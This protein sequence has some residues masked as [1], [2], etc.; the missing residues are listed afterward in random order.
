M[1][2]AEFTFP[3]LVTKVRANERRIGE[4]IIVAMQT[5][6]GMLFD[7]E[8]NYNGHEAWAKPM[9]REGQA[10][11]ARGVLKKSLA[12]GTTNGNAGPGGIAQIDGQKY[13]IGTDVAYAAMMNFG[14]TKM[15]DG[16]MRPVRAKA[17]RIPLPSGK[18]ATKAAKTL[19]KGSDE[20]FIYR[21]WVRIPERRFD[22]ITQQDRE[23]FDAAFAAAVA[24]VLRG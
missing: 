12:P 2:A 3:D 23:E 13:T 5:N 6:R 24:E 15:P 20:G 7:A 19:R 8:G 10:L 9:L 14:T 18:K 1:I 11:A 22:V 21:K 4:E 16:I 17:L